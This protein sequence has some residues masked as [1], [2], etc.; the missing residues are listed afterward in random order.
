MPQRATKFL[1]SWLL[2]H[3]RGRVADETD[4]AVLECFADALK[5]GIGRAEIQAAA[6][7]SL[8]ILIRDA[9]LLKNAL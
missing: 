5:V 8:A 4:A 9:I 3:L 2:D 6:H 1:E 7:G